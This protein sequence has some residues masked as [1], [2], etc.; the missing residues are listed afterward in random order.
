MVT[1]QSFRIVDAL[2]GS[3]FRYLGRQHREP[4][5][6]GAGLFLET[7][8]ERVIDVLELERANGRPHEARGRRGE[9][10]VE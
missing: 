6:S 7:A 2:A 1:W 10:A 5:G 8:G 3:G 9:H 4:G